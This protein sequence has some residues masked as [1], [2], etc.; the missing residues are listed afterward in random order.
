VARV[1]RCIDA[2]I[3]S[4]QETDIA[5]VLLAL[6]QGLA[7]QEA[8]G[9]LGTSQASVDRRWEL[10]IRAALNGLGAVAEPG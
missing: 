1:R 6:A 8:A 9:W 5:H 2:G 10:A 7:A 3:L 4:G